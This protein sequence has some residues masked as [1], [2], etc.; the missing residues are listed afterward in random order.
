MGA[1]DHLVEA[2]VISIELS[3]GLREHRCYIAQRLV[4]EQQDPTFVKLSASRQNSPV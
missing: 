4:T 1:E 3:V 2:I